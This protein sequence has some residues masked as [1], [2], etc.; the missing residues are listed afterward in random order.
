[1]ESVDKSI[2]Q[3]WMLLNS[4]SVS[5]KEIIEL[6]AELN[7]LSSMKQ[8]LINQMN[9]NVRIRGISSYGSYFSVM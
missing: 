4:P 9:T 5:N 6:H 1:M 3:V 7:I 8:D 2:Q